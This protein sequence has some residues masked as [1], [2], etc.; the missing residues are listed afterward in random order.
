MEA[1]P[2]DNKPVK[3]FLF[4]NNLMASF[5]T[6]KDI[7][8]YFIKRDDDEVSICKIQ[9]LL[10]TEK[11]HSTAFHTFSSIRMLELYF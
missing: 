7:V 4:F 8:Y 5:G 10:S 1:F 9:N 2:Y 11:F 6:L 3:Y